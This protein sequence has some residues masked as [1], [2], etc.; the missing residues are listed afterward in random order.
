MEHFL[1]RLHWPICG[2]SKFLRA[3]F[4]GQEL[5]ER[6]SGKK[7]TDDHKHLQILVLFIKK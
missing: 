2:V 5:R 1:N 6:W 4:S 3:A 7:S